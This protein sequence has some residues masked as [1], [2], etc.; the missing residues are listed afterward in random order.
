MTMT[1]T[2][3]TPT[4]TGAGFPIASGEQLLTVPGSAQTIAGI[5]IPD[6]PAAGR[7]RGDP[8]GRGGSALRSFPPGVPFRRVTRAPSWSAARPGAAVRGGNVSRHRA[9]PALPHLKPAL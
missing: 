1:R 9:H 2:H 6:T 3:P 8:G 7:H 4:T 5:T